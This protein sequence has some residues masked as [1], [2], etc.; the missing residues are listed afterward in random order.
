MR[1][2]LLNQFYP[3][4]S[5]PTGVYL[6]DLARA[7]VARGHEVRVFASAH[8]YDGEGGLP[9]REQ[10]DGVDVIR[11]G[12]AGHD[13]T[14]DWGRLVG[15]AGYATRLGLQIGRTLRADV[16]VSLTSPPMLGWLAQLAGALTRARVVHWVMDVYPDVLQASGLLHGRPYA[17]AQLLT[18]RAFAGAAAVVT[19][20]AGMSRRLRAYVPHEVP[21]ETIPLWMPPGLAP[22][23]DGT[24]LSL[25]RVRGWRDEET[26]LL[27]SGNLGRGHRFGEL[28]EA[29][30]RLGP[31]GPRWVFAG[32]GSA[33]AR[34]EEFR[35]RHPE[36]AIE[37]VAPA[38]SEALREHLSSADVHVASLDPEWEGAILPSK[39]QAAFA[40]GRP[41]MFVGP[42]DGD[43]ARWIR[44]SGGG[45]IVPP[46]DVD[47]LVRVVGEASD[48]AEARRR[49][50]RARAYALDRFDPTRALAQ[51][52][53]T[54]ERAAG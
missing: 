21:L 6:H 43:L 41:V 53:E 32:R 38:S 47:A 44:E 30:E 35:A 10:L 54:I 45:W 14:S 5:A 39:L 42:G 34:I 22:W 12:G 33:C 15:H 48:R 16:V 2:A 23:P 8:R 31:R 49:G 51:M 20:G 46:G 11:L 1:I 13:R 9:A 36:L 17:L 37:L 19:I 52:M 3:P 4:D 24:P 18:R 27:Y 26:V 28:L 25:R 50:E 29:S 40:V 7:L